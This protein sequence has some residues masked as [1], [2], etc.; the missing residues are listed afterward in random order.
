M[1]RFFDEYLP[2]KIPGFPCYSSPRFSTQITGADSGD[3]QANR[4]W[5]HPL[6][7]FTLPEAVRSQD[8]YEA[9]SAHWLV[10]GGPAQTW[11]FRDPLDFGSLALPRPNGTPAPTALDQTIGTG[12]G[13]TTQYQLR[14]TYVRGAKSYV[15][16]IHLPVAAS[17]VVSVNAVVLSAS[18][19][20]V[21]RPG[22]IVT[23]GTAAGVGQA[24]KAGYLFDCEVRFEDDGAF[25]GI[26]R[27]WHAAGFADLSF[28]EA[29]PS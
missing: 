21:S 19:F 25:D 5:Q 23:L 20:A 11:P 24:V 27:S 7:R 17:V 2:P 1:S 18:D 6:R 29:R 9:I 10:M 3:E 14:K 13:V 22:G 8:T 4:R 12:D 28:I 15:R 26:V 16:D